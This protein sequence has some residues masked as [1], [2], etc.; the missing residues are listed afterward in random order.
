MYFQCCR[1][2]SSEKKNCFICRPSTT[3]STWSSFKW[4]ILFGCFTHSTHSTEYMI[5]IMHLRKHLKIHQSPFLCVLYACSK[6]SNVY[7]ICI[8]NR[9]FTVMNYNLCFTVCG[10]VVGLSLFLFAFDSRR[11]QIEKTMS[12]DLLYANEY[13]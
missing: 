9:Q 7:A 12:G 13:M 10:V 8:Y 6:S 2:F 3:S 1:Q 4:I 11:N 5:Y